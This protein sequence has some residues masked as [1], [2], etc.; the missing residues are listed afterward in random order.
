MKKRIL[1][2][3]GKTVSEKTKTKG[4][5]QRKQRHNTKSIRRKTQK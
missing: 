2:Y 3:I 5:D 4:P 1:C